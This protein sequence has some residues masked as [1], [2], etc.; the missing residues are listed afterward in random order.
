MA[1]FKVSVISNVTLNDTFYVQSRKC[2]WKI[3]VILNGVRW[4]WLHKNANEMFSLM[5]AHKG[6]PNGQCDGMESF[7]EIQCE[8]MKYM[9]RID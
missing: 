3:Q 1:Y 7:G 5:S 9:F 2:A 4:T 6:R 8:E